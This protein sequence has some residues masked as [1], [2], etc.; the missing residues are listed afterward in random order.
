[1][2]NSSFV[3]EELDLC[4]AGSAFSIATGYRLDG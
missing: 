2:I 1:M 3:D 4:S